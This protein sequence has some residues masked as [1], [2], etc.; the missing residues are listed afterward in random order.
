MSGNDAKGLQD[1]WVRTI[2]LG[3]P[4]EEL[5]DSGIFWFSVVH[6]RSGGERHPTWLWVLYVGYLHGNVSSVVRMVH[7]RQWTNGCCLAVRSI[8]GLVHNYNASLQQ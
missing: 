4:S 2:E 7:E 6:F 1:G 5:G 8:Q 3:V